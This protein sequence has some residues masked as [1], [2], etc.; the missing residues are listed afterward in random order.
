MA[1]LEGVYDLLHVYVHGY[2]PVM[3]LG[4]KERDGARVRKHYAVPQTA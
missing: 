1:A 3:K 2:L 4:G